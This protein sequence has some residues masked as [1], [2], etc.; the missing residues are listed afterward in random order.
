MARA[1]GE[2]RRRLPQGQFGLFYQAFARLHEVQIR[3]LRQ[4]SGETT[5][6]EIVWLSARKGAEATLIFCQAG[7]PV[8]SPEEVEAV[9]TMGAFFQYMDD[10]EDRRIDRAW[11][12]RTPFTEGAR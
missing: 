11:V 10:F 3:S 12:L 7:K 9:E 8:L 2:I 1:Y 4:S 5:I 6:E